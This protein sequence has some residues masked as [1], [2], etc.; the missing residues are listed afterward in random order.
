MSVHAPDVAAVPEITDALKLCL[1]Y[2]LID[3]SGAVH[4]IKMK[5]V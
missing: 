1:E 5:Q 4:V 2:G 3:F